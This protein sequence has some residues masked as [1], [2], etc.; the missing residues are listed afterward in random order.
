MKVTFAQFNVDHDGKS[1]GVQMSVQCVA[2]NRTFTTVTIYAVNDQG[3]KRIISNF[4]GSGRQMISPSNAKT[5]LRKGLISE[6]VIKEREP[7][8]TR[9]PAAIGEKGR[10]LVGGLFSEAGN[11]SGAVEKLVDIKVTPGMPVNDQRKH[12]P[13]LIKKIQEFF[14]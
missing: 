13:G 2:D 12:A 8:E 3:Q 10:E 1:Y 4:S 7:K 5:F 11:Y 9:A 14:S 6:G